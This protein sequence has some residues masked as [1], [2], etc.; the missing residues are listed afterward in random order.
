METPKPEKRHGSQGF[1]LVEL[2]VVLVVSSIVLAGIYGVYRAQL[3]SHVT[4]NA[5]VDIQQNL[6]NSLYVLQRSIRMAGF[7]PTLS[8]R[9]NTPEKL[10]V[11]LDFS[12]FGSPHDASGA[13]SGA[14]SIAFTVDANGDLVD[15]A[16]DLPVAGAGVIE[17]TDSE[18]VA[19]RLSGSILQKYR[20]SN[21]DWLEVAENIQS[22]SFEYLD[23]A[24]AP[25]ALPLTAATAR[26]VRSV[27]IAITAR[28]VQELAV[29]ADHKPTT[30]LSGVVRI[31]NSSL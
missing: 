30:L 14:G 10:G 22:L 6:R 20:P 24:G 12:A 26:D 13:A 4:Q 8:V 9:S 25:V 21:G 16:T 3:K 17:A 5:V 29:L 1:S 2:M 23:D 11:L 7:D 15:E 19:F 27:R 28:P 18:L 31:R